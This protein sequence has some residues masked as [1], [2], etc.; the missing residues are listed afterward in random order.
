[1]GQI[2]VP[3]RTSSMVV[4]SVLLVVRAACEERSHV[5]LP[6]PV[7]EACPWRIFDRSSSPVWVAAFKEAEFVS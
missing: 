6:L 4:R 5:I 7:V 3:D 1:M 2:F